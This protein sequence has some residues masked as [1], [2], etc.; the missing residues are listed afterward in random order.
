[1]DAE[2]IGDVA[3]DGILVEINDCHMRAARHV[4]PMRGGIDG[5]I[6]PATLAGQRNA[7]DDVICRFLSVHGRGA[8]DTERKQWQSDSHV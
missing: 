2:S 3:D 8:E 5:E 6:I 1:M 7:G 4:Q